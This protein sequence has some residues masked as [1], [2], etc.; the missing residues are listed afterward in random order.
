MSETGPAYK[1]KDSVPFRCEGCGAILFYVTGGYGERKR[2]LIEPSPHG[3]R[4]Y[5]P[6]GYWTIWCP[7]PEPCQS[8]SF[9]VQ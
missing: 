5:C 2:L 3:V 4:F 8:V 9:V 1:L 6:C 7:A